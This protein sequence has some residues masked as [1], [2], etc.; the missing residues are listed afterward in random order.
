MTFLKRL[1]LSAAVILIAGPVKA[2]PVFEPKGGATFHKSPGGTQIAVPY[3]VL[4]VP[5]EGINYNNGVNGWCKWKL[6]G[7]RGDSVKP[8]T[9]WVKCSSTG[10]SVGQ[11]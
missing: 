5:I 3:G 1:G 9:A 10:K 11:I 4:L 2:V 6:F 7:S 8:P